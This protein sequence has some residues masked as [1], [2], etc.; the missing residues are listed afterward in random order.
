MDTFIS[1][2]LEKFKTARVGFGREN[3]PD[4][5]PLANKASVT[6]VSR[7]VKEAQNQGGQLIFGGNP[8]DRPGY[9]FEPTL[10]RLNDQHAPILQE[11]VFGPVAVIVPF[12]Q[13]EE[14]LQLANNTDVGLASYVYS[15][16][17]DMLKYF[18][19]ELGKDQREAISYINKF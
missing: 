12:S 4:M 17:K 18:A 9:Y 6:R 8:I 10:I 5:G 15:G 16:D 2:M 13:K 19:E 14:V 11:E 1:G 3:N 7:F